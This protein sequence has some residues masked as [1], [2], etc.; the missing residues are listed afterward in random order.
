MIF[1]SE[2]GYD[3][4]FLK[5]ISHSGVAQWYLPAGRQGANELY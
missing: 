2:S 5:R 4:E 1:I 3:K